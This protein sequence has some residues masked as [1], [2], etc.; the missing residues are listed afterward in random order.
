MTSRARG[1]ISAST[2]DLVRTVA[3]LVG[4]L[5]VIALAVT[6]I[7]RPDAY[8][9]ET[10]DYERALTQVRAD[11][12]YPVLAPSSLPDG[13]RATSV[14]HESDAAG[15]RWRLGFMIG[16]RG[17]VGLEQSDGEIVSYLSERLRDFTDDGTSVVGGVTWARMIQSTRPADRALVL[18]Q[19]D[20]VTI[21]RG[22]EPYD[23]LELFAAGL[24][25]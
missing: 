20:V 4:V 2:G 22:T 23:V 12:P 7:G 21:V 24:E 5:A 10:V 11:F 16:D 13:W 8:E 25:S 18:V 6:S 19:G 9:R 14:S 1:S 3:I 15:H 17:Y